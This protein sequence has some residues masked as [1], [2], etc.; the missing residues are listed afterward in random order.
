VTDTSSSAS[1][2]GPRRKRPWWIPFF[3][4][5][6]PALEPRLLSLLG[7]VS[8]AL[9]FEGYDVSMLTSA[10]KFIAEDLA[11]EEERL[12][13]YTGLIRL[14]AL[15][16][17]LIVPLADW[18]GRRRI[19]LASIVGF[20]V[21]TCLSAF[22]MDATQFILIQMVCR[23]FMIA[24][25]ATSVA[26]ITEEFPA[27]HRGW[28]IG[29]MG[30]L[31]ACGHGLGAGLFA[32][33]EYL[34][35]GWRSLYFIGLLPLA[36]LGRLRGGVTE[37]SR[38]HQRR[39]EVLAKS[40]SD[41]APSAFASWGRPL[42]WLFSAYPAR[43]LGLTLTALMSALG[44]ASAFQF[45]GYYLLNVHGWSPGH[46]S[47]MVITAGAFGIVG[48]VVAGRLGDSWGRRRVGTLFLLTFPISAWL[49]YSGGSTTLPL[50]WA[51]IVFSFT[52]C[53]VVLKAL[54]TELFPTSYRGTAAGWL[55]FTQTLGWAGGLW[56]HS[57][58]AAGLGGMGAAAVIL[59]L[60]CVIGVAPILTLPETRRR[61][62]EDISPEP[63]S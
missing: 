48:N 2:N 47:L 13:F 55:A 59:S 42:L 25:A 3:L 10:L 22:A 45:S 1:P 57:L 19:F 4:G 37:T 44:A 40:G 51:M 39:N 6:V 18:L 36:L 9:F 16:A 8:L 60:F 31:A 35:Y 24:A 29:I 23:M 20:S 33:I 38:F 62:L 61:E 21:C 11:M 46:Y 27:Q 58:A 15:P 12:G 34:P 56:L 54:A 49:F 26:I 28:A 41:P 53:D 52:A 50:A 30:A 43:T 63:A 7:F 32:A 14:G 5:A 17:I